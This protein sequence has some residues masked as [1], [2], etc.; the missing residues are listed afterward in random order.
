M[1][2]KLRAMLQ[3]SGIGKWPPGGDFYIHFSALDELPKQARERVYAAA[4]IAGEPEWN[5]V[6][7]GVNDTVSLLLYP[8]FDEDPHPALYSYVNVDVDGGYVRR[9]HSRPTVNPVILHRRELFVGPNHPRY[10]EWLAFSELEDEAGLLWRSDIGTVRQWESFLK[11]RGYKIE[12]GELLVRNPPKTKPIGAGICLPSD[13]VRMGQTAVVG[14]GLKKKPGQDWLDVAIEGL[15]EGRGPL[16]ARFVYNHPEIVEE[17]SILDF[18]C[19]GKALQVRALASVGY[20]IVGYDWPSD[21]NDESARAQGYR[22]SVA[23][24]ALDPDALEKKFDFVLASNVLNV[25]PTWPCFNQTMELIVRCL[26]KKGTFICNLASTP[27]AFRTEDGS[28]RGIWSKG[29]AGDMELEGELQQ[30]FKI[31][32]RHQKSILKPDGKPVDDWIWTC[33]L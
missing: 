18:G 10:A 5:L 9:M 4:R 20:N 17:K 19:G 24:G 30:I 2:R 29:R 8:T 27:R 33:Q 22:D 25:Q 23:D 14:I 13:Y 11:S 32:E 15:V 26:E 28:W 31:V 21:E 6:K 7:F 1:D 3:S 16:V 12:N